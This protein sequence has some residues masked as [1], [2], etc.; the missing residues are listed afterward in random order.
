MNRNPAHRKHPSRAQ[1]RKQK[2]QQHNANEQVLRKVPKLTTYFVTPST[3]EKVAMPQSS[4]QSELNTPESDSPQTD[5]IHSD[6]DTSNSMVEY[7]SLNEL[8]HTSATTTEQLE[9]YRP[10]FVA[11]SVHQ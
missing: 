6:D 2:C 9:I 3:H 7:Q 8:S 1:K 5:E 11:T 4:S 10:C